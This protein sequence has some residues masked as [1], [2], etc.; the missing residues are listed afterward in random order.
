MICNSAFARCVVALANRSHPYL[1]CWLWRA[2]HLVTPLHQSPLAQFRQ[3]FQ[4]LEPGFGRYRHFGNLANIGRIY[5]HERQTT[6]RSTITMHVTIAQTQDMVMLARSKAISAKKIEPS[7]TIGKIAPVIQL[8]GIE[9][10]SP[11]P[12]PYLVRFLI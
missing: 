6:S 7:T 12:T 9:G 10:T 4:A 8:A 11:L 1:F 5:S 3:P 2:A